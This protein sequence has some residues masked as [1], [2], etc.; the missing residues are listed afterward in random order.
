MTNRYG[1]GSDSPGRPRV[2]VPRSVKRLRGFSV[3]WRSVDTGSAIARFAVFLR[4]RNAVGLR[5]LNPR[6]LARS[7]TKR[8]LPFRAARPGVY[9]FTVR[10]FDRAG[11]A[12]PLA[13]TRRSVEQRSRPSCSRKICNIGG[14]K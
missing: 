2:V 6:V 12:S 3:A 8:V 1:V 10:A 4:P 7:T 11:N 5:Q 13:I 14:T 9:C